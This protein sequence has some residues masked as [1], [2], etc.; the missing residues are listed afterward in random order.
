MLDGL[1][2][3]GMSVMPEAGRATIQ[4][5]SAIDG[6]G[7]PWGD[8]ALYAELMLSW[9]LRAARLCGGGRSSG[10]GSV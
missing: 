10:S 7:V 3:Q 8:R 4:A 1:R 5:Q 2:A 9:E 6:P